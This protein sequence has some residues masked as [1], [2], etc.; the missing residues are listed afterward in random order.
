MNTICSKKI[1]VKI[2]HLMSHP[3]NTLRGYE[4][5]MFKNIAC[6]FWLDL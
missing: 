6:N 2:N 4:Q 5:S 1:P 3:V